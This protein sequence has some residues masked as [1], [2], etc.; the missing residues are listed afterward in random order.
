MIYILLPIYHRILGLGSYETSYIT[1][2][3]DLICD[4]YNDKKHRESIFFGTHD[5]MER[6]SYCFEMEKTAYNFFLTSILYFV[7]TF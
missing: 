3:M 1:M 2:A 6:E 4:S 5:Q 7:H